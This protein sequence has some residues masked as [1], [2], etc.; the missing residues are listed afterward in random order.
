MMGDWSAE[1]QG[2]RFA[3]EGLTIPAV[4]DAQAAE[5][6][7]QALFTVFGRPTSCKVSTPALQ[8]PTSIAL[9][10]LVLDP[11]TTQLVSDE[12]QTWVRLA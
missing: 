4:L 7:D 12:H 10:T 8:V 9:P 3:R 6:P 2:R 1:P 11:A 5:R